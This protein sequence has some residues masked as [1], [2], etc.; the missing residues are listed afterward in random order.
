MPVLADL[1]DYGSDAKY[2]NGK[3]VTYTNTDQYDDLTGAIDMTKSRNTIE[4]P[5]ETADDYAQRLKDR[6]TASKIFA[7]ATPEA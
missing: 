5:D 7:A 2:Y 1:T 3:P 6:S 4:R